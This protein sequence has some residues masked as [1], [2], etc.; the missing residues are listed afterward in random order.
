MSEITI[1]IDGQTIRAQEG[2]TI[3]NI[4]RAN[5]IY[6]PAICYL[7]RCSASLAC[8]LC[9]VDVDGKRAYS[10]N[11]KAKDGMSVTLHNEEIQAEREAIMQVYDINHPLQCGVCDK[12]G[13]CE[14]QDNT[15]FQ[16]ID[17]QPYAIRDCARQP[18][19]WNRTKYDPALC[20][21]CERCVTVC[22]DM[23]GDAALKTT[24]RGGD[25]LPEGAKESMP[26]D[27]YTIW[28]KMNKSL[29]TKIDEKCT[30]CGECAAVCPTGA[31]IFTH[32]QYTTN[33]WELA[34]TPSSCAHCS[35][36]CHLIYETKQAAID[37]PEPTMY[38]VK[39]DFHF[40]TLCGAGRFGYDYANRSATRDLSAFNRALEALKT[41]GSIRFSS[42]ITN[43]EALILQRLKERHG[44]RLINP[45]AYAFKRFLEAFTQASGRSLYGADSERLRKSD[46]AVVVGSRLSTDNPVVRFAVANM[47]VTNKGAALFFHPTGDR[48]MEGLHK[49]ILPIRHDAG[50]EE[51]ILY[52]IL[53]RFADS[54]ALPGELADYLKSFSTTLKE[55]VEESIT[56]TVTK[57][58]G[59]QEQVKKSVTK[60]I[61][62]QAS[63]LCEEFGVHFGRET[64]ES[65]DKLLAKKERYTLVAGSDLFGHP[66]WENLAR[67]LGLIERYTPFEVLLLPDSANTLGTALICD[68]DAQPEGRVVGYNAPGDFT[69]SALGG[70]DLDMPALNQQEGTLTSLDKRVVPLYP[71]LAYHGYTLAQ[72]ADA[73]EV[74]VRWT[75][76]Y[77]PQLPAERGFQSVPFDA[78]QNHFGPDGENHRGYRL[79]CSTHTPDDRAEPIGAVAPLRKG[80]YVANPLDQFNGFTAKSPLIAQAPRLM[81]SA[82]LMEKLSLS[83]GEGVALQS[84]R[85]QRQMTVTLNPH[86]EGEFALLP[87]FDGDETLYTRGDYRFLEATITK[88]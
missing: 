13:E 59:T 24:P 63:R 37:N 72:L 11:A 5:N 67:L 66:R 21:V 55:S 69:L 18:Q 53:D 8:R 74:P 16:R 85:A 12:S 44:L 81:L 86:L 61:E 54:Q 2:E 7:S 57:E 17:S 82:E 46:L 34:A 3:L 30:D 33:A 88:G 32:F 26:K 29:I 9:L 31:L 71:A 10:C 4:A 19:D 52:W 80:V 42:Q 20:I 62:V 23:T 79:A 1:T 36:A 14:L 41:A 58:D 70:G 64:R 35:S 38:R 77:T 73:L 48:H 56:E 15:L 43:E 76:D 50:R 40:Q 51:A 47:L 60:E 45:E 65:I 78:L 22:K 83:E 84:D 49:N 25:P 6:I 75:V 27:A 87:D 39:N 68:L 28:N